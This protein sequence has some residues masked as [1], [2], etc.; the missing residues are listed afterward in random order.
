MLEQSKNERLLAESLEALGGEVRWGWRMVSVARTD[1]G[2]ARVVCEA[3]PT[4][5]PSAP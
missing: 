3:D 5:T 4:P 1:D 2:G